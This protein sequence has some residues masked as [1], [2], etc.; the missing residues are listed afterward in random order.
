MQFS[1]AIRGVLFRD[2]ALVETR[3]YKSK[4]LLEGMIIA[5]SSYSMFLGVVLYDSALQ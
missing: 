4:R 1:C 5:V 3:Q 2:T